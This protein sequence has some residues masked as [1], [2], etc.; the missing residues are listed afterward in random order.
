MKD[1][2]ASSHTLSEK[3]ENG[4]HSPSVEH[5]EQP[6]EV[7]D[8]YDVEGRQRGNL[9]AVF[10]NPIAGVPR[11]KLFEDV[12]EFCKTYGLEEHLDIFQKG[13]LISQ[14][15]ATALDLPELT[16]EEKEA[17]R[18][19]KTHKWSQPWQLYFMASK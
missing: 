5:A 6:K 2:I 1:E 19:E 13:A 8:V 18:R 4:Q 3:G 17:I 11:E 15:P 16:E 12:A 7:L 9:A 14:S 10:E